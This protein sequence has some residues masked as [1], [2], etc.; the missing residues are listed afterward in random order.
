MTGA[1]IGY[2]LDS[3][4]YTAAVARL[5]GVIK[6]GLLKAVGVA[7]VEETQLRF[8]AGVDVWGTKWQALL[9]AGLYLAIHI[10]EGE[11]VTPMLLARRHPA[12]P[13]HARR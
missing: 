10:I 11:Y 7:L 8:D 9:P 2:T 6:T 12:H 5:G 13:P 4:A 3:T 1:T